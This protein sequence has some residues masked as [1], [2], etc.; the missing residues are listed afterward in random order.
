MAIGPAVMPPALIDDL[1]ARDE[2]LGLEY[3][4][5]PDCL[6]V[7]QGPGTEPSPTQPQVVGHGL[8][9][10]L[11]AAASRPPHRESPAMGVPLLSALDLAGCWALAPNADL[12]WALRRLGWP[13]AKAGLWLAGLL[14]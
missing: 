2:I 14:L 3:L 6:V 4:G 7:V 8:S 10:P 5:V 11:R 12:P 1:K 9:Q 13:S